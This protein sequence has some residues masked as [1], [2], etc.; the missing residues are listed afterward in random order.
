MNKRNISCINALF[1]HLLKINQEIPL[2]ETVGDIIS[3]PEVIKE[4]KTKRFY[5]KQLTGNTSIT[6]TSILKSKKK[7]GEITDVE[8]IILAHQLTLFDSLLLNDVDIYE[9]VYMKERPTITF[10]SSIIDNMGNW[11]SHEIKSST[12]NETDKMKYFIKV[13]VECLNIHSYN[14]SFVIYTGVSHFSLNSIFEKLPR[15]TMKLYEQLKTAFDISKNYIV[16]RNMYAIAPTPKIPILPLWLGDIIHAE[17]SFENNRNEGGL[18]RMDA[19]RTLANVL[20]MINHSQRVTF[21]E[22]DF[23]CDQLFEVLSMKY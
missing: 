12:G 9:C 4:E 23:I 7:I 13:A 18:L 2:K 8:S 5:Q 17:T 1:T 14:M 3:I 6:N 11:V 20:L 10:Y 16:Y 15:K 21:V 22:E 19:L